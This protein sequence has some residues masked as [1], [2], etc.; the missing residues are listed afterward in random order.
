MGLVWM[1][2]SKGMNNTGGEEGASAIVP[3]GGFRRHSDGEGSE[4]WRIGLMEEEV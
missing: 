1:L 3:V 2:H 4:W